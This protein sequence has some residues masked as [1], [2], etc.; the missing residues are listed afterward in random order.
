MF[1]ICDGVLRFED[2]ETQPLLHASVNLH[3][4]ARRVIFLF[5]TRAMEDICCQILKIRQLNYGT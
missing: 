5:Y 4:Y 1:E 2:G 3:F